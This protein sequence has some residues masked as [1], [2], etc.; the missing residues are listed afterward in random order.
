MR[1]DQWYPFAEGEIARAVGR[2]LAFIHLSL[3]LAVGEDLDRAAWTG[4]A[5]HGASAQVK[6]GDHRRGQ[7]GV[8]A[9]CQEDTLLRQA[10]L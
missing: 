9:V 3:I 4:C 2:R 6:A 1:A 10:A 7:F 5:R 8:A